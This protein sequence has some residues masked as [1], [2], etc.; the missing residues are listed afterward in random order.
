MSYSFKIDYRDGLCIHV[1][2]QSTQPIE[3][4]IVR[5]FIHKQQINKK[6]DYAYNSADSKAIIETFINSEEFDIPWVENI[7]PNHNHIRWFYKGFVP[8]IIEIRHP[9]TNEVIFTEKFDLRN[10]L[11]NFTL[12][13]EDPKELHT[14]MCVIDN[15]RKEWGCDISIINTHLHQTQ[16]YDWVT[17]YFPNNAPW[18]QFYAGY[19]IGRFGTKEA[20]DYFM[21]PDGVEGKNSLE[22]IDD[23][24]NFFWTKL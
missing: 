18:D 12:V 5:V 15:F 21:N 24:L 10:R 14:W 9:E 3:K 17:A 1:H 11:I 22:I 13:S 8:Y 23:I 2:D 19:T 6:L 16:E 4:F 7:I 20:P